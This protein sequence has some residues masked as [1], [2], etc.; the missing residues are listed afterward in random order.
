M[1][2]KRI[3]LAVTEVD[4]STKAYASEMQRA[5]RVVWRVRSLTAVE[6]HLDLARE[7]TG[8]QEGSLLVSDAGPLLYFQRAGLD[9]CERQAFGEQGGGARVRWCLLA[10]GQRVVCLPSHGSSKISVDGTISYVSFLQ[11]FKHLASCGR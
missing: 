4:A 2:L 11:C 5:A 3:G 10:D 8:V 7:A 6:V 9:L 1:R